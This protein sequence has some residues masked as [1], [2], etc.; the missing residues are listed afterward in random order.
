MTTLGLLVLLLVSLTAW[1]VAPA[2]AAPEG[3][4]TL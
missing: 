1:V 3:Q 4:M 2:D